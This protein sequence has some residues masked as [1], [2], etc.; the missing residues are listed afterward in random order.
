[1]N[2]TEILS[3][4]KSNWKAGLTVA[5]INI[6]LSISLA[7]ASGATP[8]QWIITAIWSG[9]IAAF[10]ASSNYNVFGVAGALS[11][12]LFTFVLS[13]G[14]NWAILLPIIAV[15]SGFMILAVYFLKITKYITL[16]PSTVLHWFLIS[17]WVTIALGQISGALGLNNPALW[18]HQHEEIYMNLYEIFKHISSID[19]TSFWVFAIGFV[20]LIFTKKRFPNFPA[21]IILTIIWISVWLWVNNWI[22]PKILLLSD[23]FPA[24]SFSLFQFPFPSLWINNIK[25]IV[26]II[27]WVF[28]TSLVVAIIAILETIISARIAEKMTK[29]KFRKNKEVLGL[30]LSNIWTGL[31][32][33]LPVTAVFIRTALNIKSGGTHKTAGFLTSVFTLIISALLFNGFFKFLPFPIIAAILM[34]IAIGLIDISLLK[35]LYNLEKTAF[36]ITLI[37]T[38]L[39]VFWEP[40]YWILI[41]TTIT[42][43]IYIKKIT[44]LDA[45]VSVFRKW[46]FTQKISLH[47]YL[48]DQKKW[49]LILMK[50]STWLN[51][52]NI[53]HNISEIRHLNQDQKLIISLAHISNID[54]D[55]I[56][57]LDEIVETLENNWVDVYLAGAREDKKCISKL[58]CH[59]DLELKWKIFKS[60]SEALGKLKK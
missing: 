41:W 27:K 58:H 37:T 12:I 11:S 35:K 7:V 44:N 56:E 57:A 32:G 47:S 40:T 29:Q 1:M 46:E 55:G 34:N 59:K 31:L 54:V 38:F 49:D 21:V 23:K 19:L 33:W 8:L 48:K 39:S 36:A 6:P 15:I 26:E 24:L 9:I 5:M 50:F 20:F 53:E 30:A 13:H 51:Y 10:F 60:S 3:N 18:I 28:K 52:L 43:F 16:L 4:L 25:D 14:E 22:L 17:V 42:L 2:T 45:N